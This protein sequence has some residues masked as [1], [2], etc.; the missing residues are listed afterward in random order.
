MSNI[1]KSVDYSKIKPVG[2]PSSLRITK[3]Q[4]QSAY[5]NLSSSDTIRFMINAPGYWDPYRTYMNLSVDCSQMGENYFQQL[6]GSAHSFIQEMIISSKGTEIERIMEYDTLANILN[7]IH[8]TPEQ[9]QSRGHEGLGFTN[10]A[11]PMGDT[12]KITSAVLPKPNGSVSTHFVSGSVGAR[13]ICNAGMFQKNNDLFIENI[14]AAA[15]DGNQNMTMF[16]QLPFNQA[17]GLRSQL[18]SDGGILEDFKVSGLERADINIIQNTSYTMHEVPSSIISAPNIP[19]VNK[20][21]LITTDAKQDAVNWGC[22]NLYNYSLSGSS[23]EPKFS[24]NPQ[25]ITNYGRLGQSAVIT[26]GTFSI[27]LISGLFGILMPAESF[28]IMPMQA[29]EDLIIEF[30]LSKYAMF[31]SGY[32]DGG[33]IKDN[34]GSGLPTCMSTLQ[35]NQAPRSYSLTKFEIVTELVEFNSPEIDIIV[36]QQLETGIVFHSNSWYNGPSFELSSTSNASGTFQV[37]L[38]F[39]SLK[40][41]VFCFVSGDYRTYSFCRK[42][43]RLSK[44]ITW[45]QVR[46]GVDYFPSQPIEGHAGCSFGVTSKG[47]N[48]EFLINLYKAFGKLHDTVSDNFISIY[49]FAVNERPYDV[50]DTRAMFDLGSREVRNMSTSMGLPGYYENACV[51]KAVFGLNLESLNSDFTFISGVNTIKNRPFDINIKSDLTGINTPY[52]RSSTMVTFCLYDFLLEV[53]KERIRVIGRG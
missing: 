31:T 17:W 26:Q 11:N 21:D 37:N 44:N 36:R 35:I 4:P 2:I 41:L 34:G 20:S 3:F 48:N 10:R 6:D 5:G 22:D 38:G 19:I 39:E 43:Y 14:N 28:R 29:F 15:P 8:Y 1:P 46:I 12:A 7:D 33:N 23:F 51:G 24:K 40:A 53:T 42:Q 32:T 47:G 25:N 16:S 50:T 52:D 30:R 13:A 18:I 9:R 27:P 49:N 45:M